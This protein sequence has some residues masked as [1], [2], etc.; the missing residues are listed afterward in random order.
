MLLLKLSATFEDVLTI[1]SLSPLSM[2]LKSLMMHTKCII[3]LQLITLTRKHTLFRKGRGWS[4]NHGLAWFHYLVVRRRDIW[5]N[6]K[7]LCY[8]LRRLNDHVSSRHKVDVRV[9]LSTTILSRILI[10]IEMHRVSLSIYHVC[11]SHRTTIQTRFLRL[12]N[13][14]YFSLHVS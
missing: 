4:W 8:R 10:W 3:A 12:P 5:D 14:T 9:F 13:H 1:V 7:F 11:W 2:H 6:L